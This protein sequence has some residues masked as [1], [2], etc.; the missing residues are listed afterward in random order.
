MLTLE[1]LVIAQGNFTLHADLAVPGAARVAIL[2]PSGGGK[3][4]LLGAIAGFMAPA[5]GRILWQ[6]QDIRHLPPSE[7]PV[8]ILFQDNNLFPH[9]TAAQNIGLGLRADLRLSASDQEKVRRA[10]ERTGLQGLGNRRPAQLSGGQQSRVALARM[11]LQN[12]PLMLLDEPFSALGPALRNEMLA[13]LKDLAKETGATVLLV[14]HDPAEAR[15]FAPLAIPVADGHVHPP[16]DTVAL[17]ANPPSMLAA[18]L[19]RPGG[20]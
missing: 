10:L 6:G 19:G 17:L 9:L 5:N 8:S 4:T 20:M 3:S 1:D 2:G 15:L 16:A 14:T 13:L 11:L 7:R 12:K 18:Y